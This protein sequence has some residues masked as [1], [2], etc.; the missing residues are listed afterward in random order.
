MPEFVALKRFTY[1]HDGV[2]PLTAVKGE[3]ADIPSQLVE[4]L[5]RDGFIEYHTDGVIPTKDLGGA[6]ENK[7]GDGGSENKDTGPAVIPEDWESLHW[8]KKVQLAEQLT[9]S[10]LVVPEGQT[11]NDVAV[12]VIKARVALD[13]AA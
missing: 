11:A 4:G 10:D 9:G 1:S 3:T 12:D 6:P 13:A 7:M 8:Q 5:V 2:T